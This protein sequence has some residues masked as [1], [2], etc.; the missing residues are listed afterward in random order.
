[1]DGG[2]HELEVY[3]LSHALGVRVHEMTMKLP[4]FEMYEEGS[5]IR[6]SAKSVSANIVEGYVL[7]KYKN[8][9]LHYLYR[10]YGSSEETL[11]HLQYLHDTGSLVEG[12][13]FLEMAESCRQLNSKL[14]RFIE[15]V[16]HQH[17]TPMFIRDI[18][19][20]YLPSSDS[21]DPKS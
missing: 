6:R 4:R 16:E 1:M 10:A 7:R 5:Q 13:V 3:Q 18:E 17:G 9:F 11:E 19:E 20:E 14:F 21:M 8:A 15:T 12:S 2:C